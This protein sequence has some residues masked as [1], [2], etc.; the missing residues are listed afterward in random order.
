MHKCLKCGTE[1][2]GKFCP[3]CGSEWEENKICPKCGAN[4][5]GEARFCTQ[6]GYSFAGKAA[7]NAIK[8]QSV[9]P[10]KVFS[11]LRFLPFAALAL[12]SVLLFAFFAAPVAEMVMGAGF[13]NV[14][15]GNVYSMQSGILSELPQ[16]NGSLVSLIF[17]TVIA[18]LYA[19]AFGAVHFV[20]GYEFKRIKIAKFEISLASLLDY[21][22]FIFYLIVFIIGVTVMG[23]ISSA[24]EGMG[25]L[26]SGAC[27]ILLMVFSIVFALLAAG[28]LVAR[29]LLAK[30]YPELAREEKMRKERYIQAETERKAQYYATHTAPVPPI[31]TGQPKKEYNRSAVIYR[32]DKRRYDKAKEGKTPAA[33]IWIDLHMAAVL[34]VVAIL[35]VAIILISVLVPIFTNK[36]RISVVEKINLGDNREQVI[37]ILGEPNETLYNDTCWQYYSD[38]YTSI[39]EKITKSIEKQEQ[40]IEKGDEK[41]LLRLADE[42]LKL[43]EQLQTV[44]YDFIE[45]EFTVKNENELSVSSVFFEKNRCDSA[46]ESTKSVMQ[47]KLSDKVGYY[48][49]KTGVQTQVKI[50]DYD[51]IKA[52]S[53]F[54]TAYF[55][56]GSLYR[57][58]FSDKAVQLNNEKYISWSDR[59]SNYS[60][61]INQMVEVGEINKAGEWYSQYKNFK[62]IFIP[63][64]VTSIGRWSFNGCE[65]LESITVSDGN[66]AFASQDGILYN[67]DKTEFVH[68]PRAIKGSVTIPESVTSISDSA[69]NRIRDTVKNQKNLLKRSLSRA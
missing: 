63:E 36:F 45:I 49:D 21:V 44:K 48:L 60:S 1:F 31:M 16:L 66:T 43:E 39:Q 38:E 59:Y 9:M 69:F 50:I 24:D 32:H 29:F 53:I 13:P 23:M 56:D 33:V 51:E 40:A 58:Y 6:C 65:S 61:S 25:L 30:K 64:N 54:Y 18:F 17:F 11:A 5:P 57:T 15:L 22:S 68:I 3:N 12:F 8:P 41:M 20:R 4:L 46:T 67:K 28:S 2:D 10:Q 37:K 52:D 34:S 47:L 19:C 55:T 14:S 35:L 27:P 42:E 7:E 26:V 62:S